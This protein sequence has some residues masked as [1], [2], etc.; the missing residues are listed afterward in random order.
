MAQTIILPGASD[1]VNATLAVL[2]DKLDRRSHRNRLRAAYYDGKNAVQRVGSIIPP[3]YYRVATTM[4]WV[5]RGV[6]ALAQRSNVDGFDWAGGKLSEL[7]ATELWD[8]N[9]LG[10]EIDQAFISTL[11]H[12]V[13]FAINTTGADDEPAGLIHFRDAVNATGEWNGRTRSLSSVL[14]VTGR[15]KQREISE[16]TLYLPNLTISARYNGGWEWSPHAHKWG[17]PVEALVHKP[18]LG[19]EFG[20]SRITRAAMQFQDAGVRAVIRLEG[21]MDVYAWPDW[22]LLGADE[23]MFQNADGSA[24][25]PFEIMLGRIKTMPDRE[26]GND[27]PHANDRADVKHFPASSPEP[28]LARLNAAAKAFAR[29]MSLPDS[30]TALTDM[31]NPTSGESYAASREE[32]IA[33][34]DSFQDETR[35]GINRVF[36]RGLA[37][38]N[39]LD[40]IPDA[41]SGMGARFRSSAYLSRA[42]AADAGSKQVAAAPWL[43]ETEVGLELLGMTP[44]QIERALKEKRAVRG[45][46]VLDRLTSDANGG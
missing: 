10:L 36:K 30:S 25:S 11:I 18:R 8:E 7:G 14:S 34:A 41:W 6:D 28:H 16:F 20:H 23:E 29:E 43:A 17:M 33:A 1:E 13:S 35:Y 27:G 12:G 39:G 2:V 42:Q 3:Q 9:R 26:P 46:A 5:A 15:N 37:M 45:R 40:E 38:R 44:Q 19:R 24:R 22:W 21:H 32:I 31:A 4:G